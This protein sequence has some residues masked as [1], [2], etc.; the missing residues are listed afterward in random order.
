VDNTHKTVRALCGE[1]PTLLWTAT[2]YRGT[3]EETR[4]LKADWGDPYIALT[5]KWAVEESVVSRPDFT[6][7]PLLNDETMD[8]VGGEFVVKE[9]EGRTE[10]IIPDVVQR[11][12]TLYCCKAGGGNYE[13]SRPTTVVCP[14][15]ASARSVTSALRAAGV[16]AVAVTGDM[17]DYEGDLNMRRQEAFRRVT[18]REAVLVQVRVV[19]EGVDLPLRVMIDLSPT[20]S[21]LLWMQRAGRITRPIG[22]GEAPPQYITTNHNLTRHAYLWN[23]VMPVAQVVAAQ[24]A[25]GPDYKPSRRTLAR[26]IGLEGF[27]KFV[28]S[29]VPLADGSAVSLYTLQTKDGLH[30]YA[31]MLHMAQPE[32]WFFERTNTATDETA[33]FTTPDGHEV[34]YRKKDYGPWKR[35]D[36]IPSTAGYLTT[37]PG[38]MTPKM[39]DWWAKSAGGRGLDPNYVPNAREFQALPI[40]LNT[41]MRFEQC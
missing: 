11:V 2:W 40:L 27:G 35:I 26:A 34:T 15:V 22:P 12:K 21:P 32:P 6:V 13:P 4:K 36:S 19:G 18:N 8:V 20:M 29:R 7:W 24:Q 16:P 23:G 31:V 30:Q 5:L 14:G 25:W 39:A 10:E 17:V 33:T 37:K 28:V 1:C 38:T 41:R 9:V 3:P